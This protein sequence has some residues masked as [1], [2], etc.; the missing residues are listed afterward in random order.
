MSSLFLFIIS[1]LLSVV[2][3]MTAIVSKKPG[4]DISPA[5]QVVV[6]AGTVP[7]ADSS[8]AQ[9]PRI[10]LCSIYEQQGWGDR[11]EAGFVDENGGLWTL[12]G[13]AS[14]LKWP[15]APEEKLNFLTQAQDLVFVDSLSSES[16]FALKS[17]IAAVEDQGNELSPRAEDAGT[18]RSYAVRYDSSGNPSCILL[19]ASGDNLFENTDDDAQALYL[20]SLRLFPDITCYG[21]NIGPAGFTP[22]PFYLF[23]GIDLSAL[24]GT[25]LSA[26]YV[27]SEEGEVP[28][29]ITEIEAEAI[30]NLASQ[31]MV[32]GKANALDVTGG[33]TI[34]RF[35]DD[36]GNVLAS[37]ALYE[38]MLL[39]DEGMYI[40]HTDNVSRAQ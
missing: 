10:I 26:V 18:Q 32:I 22:V 9:T 28:A 8:D 12:N 20:D 34:Y 15:Y 19:G 2:L 36:A 23:C 24:Y 31:A 5:P 13:Y 39:T 40:L 25:S 3:S 30:R 33:Y 1:F 38:G 35:S 4:T 21:A 37:F 29:E 7:S 16:L 11:V 17:L 27:D 6:P 14:T